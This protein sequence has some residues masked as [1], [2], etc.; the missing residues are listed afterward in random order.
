MGQVCNLPGT[1]KKWQVTNLPQVQIGLLSGE[2]W[3]PVL[4]EIA[5]KSTGRLAVG[6]VTSQRLTLA[7]IVRQFILCVLASLLAISSYESSRGKTLIRQGIRN[8]LSTFIG[9]V[10]SAKTA[11]QRSIL[12][13]SIFMFLTKSSIGA[14]ASAGVR[15]SS[16]RLVSMI[17][18][19]PLPKPLLRVPSSGIHFPSRYASVHI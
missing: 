15:P 3:R 2:S 4:Q 19:W 17:L 8:F 14:N 12:V 6:H 10:A 9:T 11:H 18:M 16:A 13:T 1:R 5:T 7:V